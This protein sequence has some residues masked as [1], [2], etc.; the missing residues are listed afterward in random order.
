MQVFNPQLTNLLPCANFAWPVTRDAVGARRNSLLLQKTDWLEIF[1]VLS[2]YRP[3]AFE[4]LVRVVITP[5]LTRQKP[6][7]LPI[8]SRA[9]HFC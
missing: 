8:E 5:S 9:Q 6:A 3:E 7:L 1:Q 2:L 4:R